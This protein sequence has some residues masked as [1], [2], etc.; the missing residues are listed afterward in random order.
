MRLGSVPR[1]VD[2]R[3]HRFELWYV[4]GAL[5]SGVAC[6]MVPMLLP[7]FVAANGGNPMLVGMS[8]AVLS[9]GCLFAPIFGALAERFHIHRPLIVLCAGTAA[10]ALSTVAS[11]GTHATWLIGTAIVGMCATG[12]TVIGGLLVADRSARD[13]W[14]KRQGVAVMTYAS[15]TAGG[16]LMAGAFSGSAASYGLQF[17][18]MALLVAA[19]MALVLMPWV[20]RK[21]NLDLG[22][23]DVIDFDGHP[24]MRKEPLPDDGPSLVELPR[25][26][27][28]LAL[29]ILGFGM[30]HL[31]SCLLFFQYP[32]IAPDL[33]RLAPG[34]AAVVFG[35]AALAAVVWYPAVGRTAR[36]REPIDVL[37]R[38]S[39]MRALL[40]GEL[41][42]L[43]AVT[44]GWS[45]LGAAALFFVYRNTWPSVYAGATEGSTAVVPAHRQGL[46]MGMLSITFGVSSLAAGVLS[47]TVATDHGYSALP[48]V[49]SAIALGAGLVFAMLRIWKRHLVR[50]ATAWA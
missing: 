33:Y 24:V 29:F 8:M 2:A 11:S 36:S 1:R 25:W 10:I 19:G 4:S 40:F 38:A 7:Q 48:P 13:D 23:G 5:I 42:L 26:R 39:W 18:G 17:G 44:V 12:A 30:L 34:P 20:P 50:K 31:A 47:G 15:G 3:T 32:L 16:L 46:A 9:I 28:P 37:T 21:R 22:T 45:A 14:T 43:A 41:A 6:G 49:A 27:S 35:L